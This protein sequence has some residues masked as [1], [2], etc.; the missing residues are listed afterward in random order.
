MKV[1]SHSALVL[2][3]VSVTAFLGCNAGSSGTG[4]SGGLGGAGGAVTAT[5]VSVTVASTTGGFMTGVGGGGG[6]G[7]TCNPGG[8]N[9]D[10]DHDGFTPMQG[11]CDDCDPNSNPNAIEVA[12]LMGHTPIDENCNG[13]I[14]EVDTTLC[15][16]T[17]AID[18]TDPLDAVKAIDLCKM[19]TGLKDW[20]LVDAK[21]VLA[22]GTPP[23]SD[24]AMRQN[25]DLGHGMLS[26]FGANVHVR[27]GQ[28]MLGL[29]SG[30]ARNPSDPGYHSVNGFSKGYTSGH[31][32]G[33]PK[34]SPACPGSVTGTPHDSAAVEI[35]VRTPSNAT[36]IAF[37]FDFYTFE[38]PSFVCST[39][40][41]FFVALLTPFPMGQTDGNISFDSQNNPISV[42]N[43]LLDVCGCPGNPP[44]PCMAGNKLFNCALGD[45]ELIQTGFGFD[46]NSGSDHGST[47]WLRTIAPVKGGTEINLRF[48]VYD[49]GDGVLDTTTLVDNFQWVATPGT[50]VGTNPV[51]N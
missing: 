23:P 15:D 28:H 17:L 33:F 10:V 39:Y 32:Q 5:S 11:D 22:D 3:A 21:W 44:N 14:D 6:M 47:S 24:L 48:A 43:A 26:G 40:N 8:P 30:S 18:S 46:T 20:G 37:D 12:T 31:P 2:A 16:A 13:Q 27:K 19:S 34:E 42:N 9:D 45:A 51:P 50:K 7:P 4:G 35:N 41:D 38:W 1:S 36:G 29:S 49:S 25:Y